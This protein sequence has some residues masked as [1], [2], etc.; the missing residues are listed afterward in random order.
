MAF[1]GVRHRSR[2]K[3]ATAAAQ[4]MKVARTIDGYQAVQE[5]VRRPAFGHRPSAGAISTS[6]ARRNTGDRRPA[7]QRRRR[8]HPGLL[9]AASHQ[10][11]WSR[12]RPH[13][14]DR[15]FP[16]QRDPALTSSCKGPC[17]SAAPSNT[18]SVRRRSRSWRSTRLQGRTPGHRETAGIDGAAAIP[19][20]QR[21]KA[22]HHRIHPHL[23]A[24][25]RIPDQR[26]GRG[27]A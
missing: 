1:A 18:W 7:R 15:L 2:S 21:R 27:G 9:A 3:A 12:R 26:R 11:S 22:G 23:R 13:R 8:R 20:R 5:S 19:D 14:S 16:T 10:R 17:C 24:H 6:R 25:I 4:G